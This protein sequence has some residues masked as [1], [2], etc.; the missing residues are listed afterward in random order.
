MALSAKVALTEVPMNT[1]TVM[2]MQMPDSTVLNTTL[3]TIALVMCRSPFSMQLVFISCT[4]TVSPLY[5]RERMADPSLLH[6]NVFKALVFLCRGSDDYAL[7]S[8][9]FMRLYAE[10]MAHM[11]GLS[12]LVPAHKA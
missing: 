7:T 4:L 3:T 8:L 11:L 1:T 9:V 12:S 2:F 5:P 10:D 6:E